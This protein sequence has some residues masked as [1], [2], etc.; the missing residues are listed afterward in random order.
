MDDLGKVLSDIKSRL[1][2]LSKDVLLS[3]LSLSYC[4]SDVLE[5]YYDK[6]DSDIKIC[7]SMNPNTPQNV[8]KELY[9][10][11]ITKYN[12]IQNENCPRE[13]L[14]LLIS[15]N[16]KTIFDALM[17][18]NKCPKKLFRIAKDI[19]L[20][21]PIC[22]KDVLLKY[23]SN[24]DNLTMKQISDLAS[25]PSMT[26]ELL[27]MIYRSKL[28]YT[29]RYSFAKNVNCSED[30]LGKIYEKN[31][32]SDLT[33]DILKNAQCPQTIIIKELKSNNIEK[34]R[35]IACN[36]N[37]PQGVL[38]KLSLIEDEEL[39][40][41]IASNKKYKN[42]DNIANNPSGNV[43]KCA[44]ENE[45][46]DLD[47][48]K[49]MLSD[50]DESIS[51]RAL[52][53]Y[54]TYIKHSSNEEVNDEELESER[55]EERKEENNNYDLELERINSVNDKLKEEQNKETMATIRELEQIMSHMKN[56]DENFTIRRLQHT[57]PINEDFLFDDNPDGSRM[58]KKEFIKVL[59]Y[60]DL[61]N[62]NCKNMIA[63]DIDF[64]FT[65]IDI[66][67]QKVFKKDLSYSRFGDNNIHKFRNF[68]GVNMTG[69]DISET[70]L[71]VGTKEK[72]SSKELNEAANELGAEVK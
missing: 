9:N 56:P 3:Y 63:T 61:S 38:D 1:D 21:N 36:I 12:V 10:D 57:I 13:I 66:D 65:N 11:K 16:D 15:T 6:N 64:R 70:R 67:P 44:L 59:K 25:N 7:L 42:L 35:A 41:N 24:A 52:F 5:E 2:K 39:L 60:L 43:R 33:I 20:S 55:R 51:L 4:P 68:N 18:N 47:L 22:P 37:I 49:S 29:A 31:N 53:K 40:C 26:D 28:G 17:K 58:I 8:L 48:I 27:N 34:Y 19:N 62:I 46:A 50:V 30:I 71:S 23:S 14:N 45:S 69:C 54:Y 72:E 32:A